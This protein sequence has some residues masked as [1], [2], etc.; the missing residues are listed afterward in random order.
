MRESASQC[1]VV[2]VGGGFAGLSA[3]RELSSRGCDVN[4]LEAQDLIET[5]TAQNL[6]SGKSS[7]ALAADAMY[8]ASR[9][10]NDTRTQASMSEISDVRRATIHNRYQELHITHA[11]GD[12]YSDDRS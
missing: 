6:H 7:A 1:D 5:G 9:L 11:N 12:W 10:T 2:I 3:A 4:S 8:A